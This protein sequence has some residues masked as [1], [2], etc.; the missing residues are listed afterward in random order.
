MNHQRVCARAGPVLVRCVCAAAVSGQ[1]LV[2]G[3]YSYGALRSVAPER[4]THVSIR[5]SSDAT[6]DLA[7]QIGP[8]V[9][10]VEGVVL[11]DDSAGLHVAVSHVGGKAGGSTSD[12]SGE[13][14]TFPHDSYLS[15]EVRHL[16]VPGTMLVG[17]LSVAAVVAMSHAFGTGGAANSPPTGLGNPTQ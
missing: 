5:L 7:L 1:L 17:G 11:G 6:R 2:S 12:W 3:C 16:S 4:G 8:G 9:T 14:F 10:Y 15:L 13:R